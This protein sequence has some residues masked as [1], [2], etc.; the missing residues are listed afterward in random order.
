M[1]LNLLENAAPAVC[2]LSISDILDNDAKPSPT[3]PFRVL[4]PQH[5]LKRMLRI[6]SADDKQGRTGPALVQTG[7]KIGD[8]KV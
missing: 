2:A 8:G 1:R 4:G 6:K 5:T 3:L 7:G